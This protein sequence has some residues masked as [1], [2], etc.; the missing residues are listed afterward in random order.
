MRWRARKRITRDMFPARPE[1]PT[2]AEAGRRIDA[3][4]ARGTR[5][6]THEQIAQGHLYEWYTVGAVEYTPL[7]APRRDESVDPIV[8]APV[9][10]WADVYA[11]KT[12]SLNGIP[13]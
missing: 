3:L 2:L 8:G 4:P 9:S 13:R 11:I 12:R 1:W 10:T 7:E 6:V 5:S